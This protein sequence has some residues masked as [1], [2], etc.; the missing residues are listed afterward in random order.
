MPPV[1]GATAKTCIH[2][3]NIFWIILYLFTY[4]YPPS[5]ESECN[6][7]LDWG[8]ENYPDWYLPGACNKFAVK[9]PALCSGRACVLMMLL[10]LLTIS[11]SSVWLQKVGLGYPDATAFHVCAGWWCIAQLF[12]HAVGFVYRYWCDGGPLI[13]P[14]KFFPIPGD[15]L[16]NSFFNDNWFNSKGLY[17]GYGAR[18]SRGDDDEI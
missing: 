8:P 4:A 6:S 9:T 12:I 16:T 7:M 10:L 14:Y 13:L 3:L 5:P 1:S 15:Y 2:G 17:V 11:R 18:D